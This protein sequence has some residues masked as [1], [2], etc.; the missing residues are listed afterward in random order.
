MT[1]GLTYPVTVSLE[2]LGNC[3]LGGL[4]PQHDLLAPGTLS[5]HLVPCA[6][7]EHARRND[8]GCSMRPWQEKGLHCTFEK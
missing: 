3:V 6:G 8:K 4:L 7:T 2:L 5:H 1:D